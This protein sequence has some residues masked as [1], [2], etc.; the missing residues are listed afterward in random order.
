MTVLTHEQAAGTPG[1]LASYRFTHRVDFPARFASHSSDALFELE[2]GPDG[3]GTDC[4]APQQYT[5]KQ[6]VDL[7][8]WRR[9]LVSGARTD[10]AAYRTALDTVREAWM[11]YSFRYID[12]PDLPYPFDL[13]ETRPESVI[14]EDGHRV[15]DCEG[16]CQRGDACST[17]VAEHT[18][19]GH[20]R[21]ICELY[22]APGEPT[23][24]VVFTHDLKADA[25]LL[26]TSDPAALQTLAS[27]F[28]R[29]A[30]RIEHAAYVLGQIQQQEAK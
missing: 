1:R 11:Q 12:G 20:G 8:T 27:E 24:A 29:F 18:V 10:A 14:V 15:P 26:R 2:Y 9:L 4:D 13:P 6:L 21:L 19:D 28:Y 25:T 30:G 5:E 7:A 16:W 23:K 17:A 3:T 22:A